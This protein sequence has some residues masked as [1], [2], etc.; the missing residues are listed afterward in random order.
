MKILKLIIIVFLCNSL[1][2]G[3]I[4]IFHK[5]SLTTQE[6]KEIAK[7]NDHWFGSDKGRHL[8]GSFIATGF[9][10]LTMKRFADQPGSKS[11]LIGVS[12]ATALGISKEIY[13]S[14]KENNIFSI[15]DLTADLTGILLAY[16]VFR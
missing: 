10:Y 5:D 11:I 9:T 7:K 13:D 12:F 2:A 4:K 15:K 1:H 3:T 14:R 8:A 16:L 6:P